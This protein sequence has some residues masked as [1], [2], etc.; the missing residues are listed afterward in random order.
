M[1]TLP[2]F[3]I[4]PE[5]GWLGKTLLLGRYSNFSGA[6]LNLWGCI[7][8]IY[9][10]LT[11]TTPPWGMKSWRLQVSI[12]QCPFQVFSL[13]SEPFPSSCHCWWCRHLC[14]RGK[15]NGAIFEHQSCFCMFFVRF[16]QDIS[17]RIP[18]ISAL[19]FEM[20]QGILPCYGNFG[21][22]YTGR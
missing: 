5:N 7:R 6:T 4:V 10:F 14:H 11:K 17:G 13:A 16:I 18:F 8:C 12:A 3:N 15:E 22:V 21:D 1:F 9:C 19:N 20:P 2:K